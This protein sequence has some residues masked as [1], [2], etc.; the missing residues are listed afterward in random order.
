MEEYPYRLYTDASDEAL[1]CALQQVQPIAVKDLHG[2][3]TYAK[4]RKAFDAG[5][6]VPQLTVKLTDKVADTA[7]EDQWGTNFD[8]T[9]VHVERVIGYWSWTFQGAEKR[10]ATTEREALA[11]KE[12]LIKFQ[13]FIEGAKV[14]LITDHS[15]LQWA[16]TYKNANRQ[17]AAW[18]V[19]FAAYPGL[20]IIHRAGR[21]HSN[22]DPL[23]R[24]PR[25]LPDHQSPVKDNEPAIKA[26]SSLAE[27]QE[28]MLQKEPAKLATFVAWDFLD[29]VEEHRSAW[30][31]T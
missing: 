7:Y 20:T 1:G 11:T 5:Q 18:G 24:L 2:T 27:A 10:Y 19:V 30:A 9:I 31:T 22:V 25:S 26:D 12:G 8:D 4:L 6:P 29:C 13:P 14:I 16:R 28:E 21:K 3:K 17:L 23:S 15:A